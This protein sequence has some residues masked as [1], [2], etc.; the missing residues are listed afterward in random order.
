MNMQYQRRSNT[1]DDGISIH[2]SCHVKNDKIMDATLKLKQQ[3]TA[4]NSTNRPVTNALI[5]PLMTFKIAGLIYWQAAKLFFVKK[6]P[7]HRHPGNKNSADSQ[8]D[9]ANS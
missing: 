4:A 9:T 2:I 5:N 1:P 3:V 6:L 8:S 7:L